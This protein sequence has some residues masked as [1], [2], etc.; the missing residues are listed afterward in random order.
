LPSGVP[1]NDEEVIAPARD[2]ALRVLRFAR[3]AGVKR[4][5]LTS[6]IGAIGYG[7]PKGDYEF[8]EADWT[9]TNHDDTH[10]Y[11]NSKAIS[12]RAARDWVAA[13]GGGMEFCSVNPAV[14]LGPIL[15]GQTS[16]SHE[17]VRQLLSGL[18]ACP[19]IGFEFVDVRDTADIHVRA[20]TE[21]GLDGERFIASAQWLKLID[22]ARI[23]K[24]GLGEAAAA[25]NV[26]EMPDH[27]MEWFATFDPVAMQFV[28][29]LGR[30][31]RMRSDH[32][33]KRLGW[34]TRPIEQTI[35]ETAQSLI[36]NKLV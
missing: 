28:D 30:T 9:D 16:S 20:L 17:A 36:E 1:D 13:E 21:P 3:D 5:V 11:V 25:V 19:D 18:P 22:I 33:R 8:T 29:E 2:G 26:R 12:E 10:A 32:A 27:V 14:V 34:T 6:S 24:A 4:F 23:L 35:L 7:R 31:R 15:G